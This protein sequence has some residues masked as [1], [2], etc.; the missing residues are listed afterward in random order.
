MYFS[1][2]VDL[3]KMNVNI[4]QKFNRFNHKKSNKTKSNEELESSANWG[5]SRLIFSN[6]KKE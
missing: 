5:L 3:K 6:S 1:D 2:F 4:N